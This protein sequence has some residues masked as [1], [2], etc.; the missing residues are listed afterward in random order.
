[1]ANS[2]APKRA[3]LLEPRRRAEKALLNVAQEADVHGVSTR[4]VDELVE[5]L[6]I[7]GISQVP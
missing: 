5:S 3:S 7:G 4:K 1:M 6:G 2:Q